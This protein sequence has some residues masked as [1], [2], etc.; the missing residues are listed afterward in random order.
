MAK[1]KPSAAELAASRAIQR[2]LGE[3]I[4]MLRL[5][6]GLTQEQLAERVPISQKY[7]SELER[8]AKSPSWQTLVAIAHKGFEIRL[9]SLLFAIDEDA[10]ADVKRLDDVLAGRPKEARADLLRAVDLLLRAGDAS[11]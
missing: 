3:R 5:Q 7:V 11:K 4:Q 6:R 1:R 8:G 2:R 9:A 10:G